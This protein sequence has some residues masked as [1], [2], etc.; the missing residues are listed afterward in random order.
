MLL[1]RD[2]FLFLSCLEGKLK[3]VLESF[4]TSSQL[5]AKLG[6]VTRG[7]NNSSWSLAVQAQTDCS[8]YPRGMPCTT[9]GAMPKQK[10]QP[11]PSPQSDRGPQRAPG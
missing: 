4:G 9:Q 2:G 1:S 10:N 6:L 8:S 5:G 7:T 3:E 11:A